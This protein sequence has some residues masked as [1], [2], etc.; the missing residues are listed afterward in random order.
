MITSLFINIV[1]RP[2][3][4]SLIFLVDFLTNNLGVAIIILT[5]LFRFVIFPL[6]KSQIKT[7][8]KMKDIQ[9]PMKELKKKY[10][11][12]P[13]EMAQQTM[14]LYRENDI[15]PF[16]GILM[17]FIQLPLLFGFYYMFIKAGLPNINPDLIY[18]FIPYPESV[19]TFFLGIDLTSKSVLLAILVG[20]TQYI[21]T[22]LLLSSSQKEEKPEE[23]SMEDIMK[24]VQTQMV[25]VLPVI[26]LFVSYT[27][28]AIVAL[29]LLT[30]NVF[31]IFQ[32]YY[33]KKTIKKVVKQP[34]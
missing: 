6:S 18:S 20:L 5:I 8:I 4:N 34:N 21:Q 17:L 11:D 13:Q 7:Q 1:V 23:G 2:F 9:G 26:I 10:K 22:K 30:S 14:K 16:A 19:N 24:K 3:Y 25:Y 15:K 29:Y 31:S 27:F 12:N 28:G 33:L 32:E